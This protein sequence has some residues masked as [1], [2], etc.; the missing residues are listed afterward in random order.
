[1]SKSANEK[2]DE[3]LASKSHQLQEQKIQ[4]IRDAMELQVYRTE[5]I[6]TSKHRQFQV[7]LNKARQAATIWSEADHQETI[8]QLECQI[9]QV[10]TAKRKLFDKSFQHHERQP[11]QEV[12]T[13]VTSPRTIFAKILFI[14]KT[15]AEEE[16]YGVVKM[17]ADKRVQFQDS[18]SNAEI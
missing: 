16:A 2:V 18:M 14:M 17:T 6:T 4:K 15:A 11:L 1:M 13:K 9:H 12:G 7:R 8:D 5:K 10:T 3:R